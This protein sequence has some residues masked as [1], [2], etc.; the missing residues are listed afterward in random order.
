MKSKEK[1]Q[2][3][4]LL[5]GSSRGMFW[6]EETVETALKLK[7]A[8]HN[9]GYNLLLQNKIPLPSIRTLQSRVSELKFGSGILTEIFDFL[10]IKVAAYK[11]EH[12]VCIFK[13]LFSYF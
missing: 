9:T 10:K 11:E 3:E 13:N 4:A 5:R 1:D 8:C 12:K 6:S 7:F 2:I